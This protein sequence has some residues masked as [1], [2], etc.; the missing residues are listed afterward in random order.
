MHKVDDKEKGS[1]SK[2]KLLT[3]MSRDSLLS[4]SSDSIGL[5]SPKSLKPEILIAKLKSYI[6]KSK[7]SNID[8]LAERLN[9]CVSHNDIADVVYSTNNES[10]RK[11]FENI[12]YVSER[13]P[14]PSPISPRTLPFFDK[15]SSESPSSY[16]YSVSEESDSEANEVVGE[17]DPYIAQ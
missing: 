3:T 5:S 1:L 14:S 2:L 12:C 13:S 15:D 4:S 16:L 8:L 10:L 11:Y 17:H 7:I 6:E 9:S